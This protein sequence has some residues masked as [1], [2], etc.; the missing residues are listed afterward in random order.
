MTKKNTYL[1]FFSALI[2]ILFFLKID[3]RYKADWTCCS[4]EF[5]Y[6]AHIKTIIEDKDFDYSNQFG[7]YR[8]A[9]NIIN[10]KPT[11]IGFIGTSFLSLPFYISGKFLSNFENINNNSFNNFELS[12]TSLS[13]TFYLFLTF[14]FFIKISNLLNI[15]KSHSEI[16]FLLLG[17]GL[18]YFAFERYL[19]PHVF[20]VFTIT[21]VFYL[22]IKFFNTE[23]KIYIMVLPYAV[24]LA[25]L[26]RWTNY[27]VLLAPIIV[28]YL[29]FGNKKI[30]NFKG[31]LFINSTIASL[32]FLQINK[33]IYGIYTV[34]P[35]KIY[36]SDS[37]RV[38]TFLTNLFSEPIVVIVNSFKASLLILF[39]PEFGIL[40]FS[41]VIFLGIIKLFLNRKNIST[42]IIF[43]C[44]AYQFSI[45]ILWGTTA[46]SYGFR[47]LLCLIPLSYIV[48]LSSKKIPFEN[49]YIYGFSLFA[50]ISTLL[51]ETTTKTQLSIDEVSNSFGTITK[52]TQPDYLYGVIE[53]ITKLDSWIIV[54][55]TSLLFSL[56]LKLIFLFIEE[57]MLISQLAGFGLPVENNDFQ[58]LLSNVQ[59]TPYLIYLAYVLFSSAIVLYYI[60]YRN[61]TLGNKL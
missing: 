41:P 36:S 21:L 47:Y 48:L 25:L 10:D 26:V 53:A 3:Y 27:H 23:S 28:K 35:L 51:F 18:T 5:D 45:V 12:M 9:R 6:Y 2:L 46:S 44:F 15:R 54:F 24:L 33:L 52:Y 40:W 57:G 17:S 7:D 38:D 37:S 43:L 4:D 50:F 56:F 58:T 14:I 32:I 59:S 29:F 34:N 60:S 16:L 31:A 22:A 55:A 20:E 13:S 49:Y 42:L 61:K 1:L 11:P 8:E 19:M 39:G 30:R